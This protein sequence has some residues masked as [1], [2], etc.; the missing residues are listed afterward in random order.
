M[1]Y[2]HNINSYLDLVQIKI[3]DKYQAIEFSQSEL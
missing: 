2:V 1:N 3:Y